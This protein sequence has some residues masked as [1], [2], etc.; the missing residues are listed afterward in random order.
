MGIEAPAEWHGSTDH[1]ELLQHGQSVFLHE[2]F[3]AGVGPRLPRLPTLTPCNSA[4]SAPSSSTAGSPAVGVA[5]EPLDLF[6]AERQRERGE[7]KR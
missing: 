6:A 4:S 2:R 3:H 5:Q 7:K 1:C